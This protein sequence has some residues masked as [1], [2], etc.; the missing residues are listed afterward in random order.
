[1]LLVPFADRRRCGI[2][3]IPAKSHI[4]IVAQRVKGLVIYLRLIAEQRGVLI[5]IVGGPVSDTRLFTGRFNGDLAGSVHGFGDRLAASVRTGHGGGYL[6]VVVRPGVR[7]F[8]CPV[9][10]FQRFNRFVTGLIL[11]AILCKRRSPCHDTFLD[12]GGLFCP[13]PVRIDGFGIGI[14]AALARMGS[15]YLPTLAHCFPFIRRFAPIVAKRFAFFG[16]S[17]LEGAVP[18]GRDPGPMACF[19]AGRRIRIRGLCRLGL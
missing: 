9:M 15:S 7:G 16:L 6:P 1:M 18:E 2:I 19:D 14:T 10:A 8:R 4:P 17:P 5:E 13:L 11:K 12:A 3:T